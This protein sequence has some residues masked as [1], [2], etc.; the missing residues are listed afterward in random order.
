MLPAFGGKLNTTTAT[1]RSA[2]ATRRSAINLS[3][4]AAN[5]MARSGQVCMSCALS[6]ALKVQA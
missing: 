6:V 2:R 5:M 3:V 4:R 1:L